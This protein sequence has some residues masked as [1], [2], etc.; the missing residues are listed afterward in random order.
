MGFVRHPTF[1][2]GVYTFTTFFEKTS[3]NTLRW[4]WNGVN[5]SVYSG[6]NILYTGA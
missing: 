3:V 4:H 2:G 6:V 1:N 5:T